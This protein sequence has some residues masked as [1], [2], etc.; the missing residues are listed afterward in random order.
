LD[1]NVPENRGAIYSVFNLTDSVGTGIGKWVGGILSVSFGMTAALSISVI[2]WVPCAVLLLIMSYLFK[3][4]ITK[5][6]KRLELAATEM[7]Q[8]VKK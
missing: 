8:V 2:M 7:T 1:V 5:M 6:H 3:A 4:D